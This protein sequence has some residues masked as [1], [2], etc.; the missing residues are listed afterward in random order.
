[1]A[2]FG[3]IDTPTP[4]ATASGKA[5]VNFGWALT[6]Q[7]NI[8][9][10]D[11]STIT[12]FIDNIA[13]GHPVYDNYRVDVSTLFPGLQNSGGPVGYFMVDTTTLANGIHTISWVAKDSAGH[14]SGLGSRYFTVQN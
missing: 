14:A 8:I 12:V 10:L 6:P 4:G 11:G 2:P 7:P 1:V 3:T 9:A 13:V 5:Y